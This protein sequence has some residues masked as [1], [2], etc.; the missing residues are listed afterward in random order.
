VLKVQTRGDVAFASIDTN[1]DGEI[2]EEYY[3]WDHG[4]WHEVASSS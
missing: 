2:E 1:G 4:R 3:L